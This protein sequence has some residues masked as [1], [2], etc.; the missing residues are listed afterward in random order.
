MLYGGDKVQITFLAFFLR[1]YNFTT[2]YTLKHIKINLIFFRMF[3]YAFDL[4][5]KEEYY[6]IDFTVM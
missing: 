4:E 3:D 2:Y 1:I 5:R 6:Y